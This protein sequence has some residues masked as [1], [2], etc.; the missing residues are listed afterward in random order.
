MHRFKRFVVESFFVSIVFSSVSSILNSSFDEFFIIINEN[1]ST[2]WID[3]KLCASN[4]NIDV[5]SKLL[6]NENVDVSNKSSNDIEL[7]ANDNNNKSI[8]I[9]KNINLF[10]ST[11]WFFFTKNFATRSIISFEKTNKFEFK[12]RMISLTMI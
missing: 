6:N 1:S 10:T 3:F 2:S 7:F 8:K 12:A 4:K 11:N 5:S 9:W